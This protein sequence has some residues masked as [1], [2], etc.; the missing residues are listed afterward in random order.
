V[1]KGY[2]ILQKIPLIRPVFP[3]KNRKSAEFEL[4]PQFE[5]VFTVTEVA[6][7]TELTQILAILTAAAARRSS[8]PVLYP[9][10][11]GLHAVPAFLHFYTD[12]TQLK[13]SSVLN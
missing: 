5:Y 6:I 4:K 12:K 1:G 8:I 3:Q 10:I 11:Q 7:V 13:L 9:D 2:F